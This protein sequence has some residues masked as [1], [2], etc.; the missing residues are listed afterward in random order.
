MRILIPLIAVILGLFAVA[1]MLGRSEQNAENNPA[2]TATETPAA[3]V[4]PN[5]EPQTPAIDPTPAP[6]AEETVQVTPQPQTPDLTPLTEPAAPLS[7]TPI[8]L[9]AEFTEP[10]TLGSTDPETGF[11]IEVRLS[12]WGAGVSRIALA[13]YSDELIDPEPYI[14][15]DTLTAPIPGAADPDSQ[16]RIRPFSARTL[17]I[18]GQQVDL[19]AVRWALEPNYEP[20]PRTT[21]TYRAVVASADPENPEALVAIER[22]FRITPDGYDITVT[23]NLRNL[24]DRPLDV[25]WVQFLQGDTPKDDAA[26]LGDRRYYV[27]GYF[28]LDY[29]DR[30]FAIYTDNAFISRMES[31]RNPQIWPA[32]DL[33]DRAELAWVAAENRY[34]AVVTHRLVNPEGIDRPAQVPPLQALFPQLNLYVLPLVPVPNDDLRLTVL[35]AATPTLRLEPQA[36]TDLS[37]AV[38]AGPREASVFEQ[39]PY[40]ALNLEK[41]IRYSLGGLIDICTF[42]WL[43]HALL[44]FLGFFHWIL[45]DWGMAIIVLVIT[46]R[47]ILHPIMK[48]S[49]L[50]MMRMG[51]IM[52]K[53]QPEIEK[54]KKKYKDDPAKLQSEQL[55]MMREAGAS[56]L[57]MLGCLPLFLQMPI[58]TALYAMLYYAIE[59][60]HEP[61]FWGIF[62]TISS[63]NWHFL[64]DLAAPDQFITL[65]GDGWDLDLYF[66]SLHFDAINILPLLMAIVFFINNKLMSPPPANEQQASMQRMMRIM[67]LIFPFF[68]YSAP[69]GLTLYMTASTGAGILDSWIVRRHLKKEEESGRLFEKKAPKPGGFMDRFGKA[70]EQAREQYEAQQA[71]KAGGGGR[72]KVA[73]QANQPGGRATARRS[74]KK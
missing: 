72:K 6:S 28:N 21:A 52:Q 26:Y 68:L 48:K 7:T 37:F 13:D 63:G 55:R 57:G 60:R 67:F 22:T 74:K 2:R 66:I 29:D 11:K 71:A 34:F 12:P 25:A 30:K 49:Q 4:A 27:P 56:P 5:A 8:V 47:L 1:G 54:L 9:E 16:Y 35:T 62:Q 50:S 15:H 39:Q 45:A 69:A 33:E 64:S 59:L 10:V 61:A 42:Q 3:Q 19:M 24:T 20:G 18:G 73:N 70:M 46:V 32:P 17:V 36:T 41:T 43:A 23:Q 14:I 65:P 40:A 51:K 38:Y 44:G 31:I 53:L 58:W